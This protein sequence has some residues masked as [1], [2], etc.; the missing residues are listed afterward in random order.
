MITASSQ[1]KDVF[2]NNSSIKIGTGCTIEYNMNSLL[3]N[4][5]VT[6]DS[7][8]ETFYPKMEDGRT[9][10]YKKLFPVDTII[11][12]FRPLYSGVKYLIWTTAQTDTPKNSFFSPRRTVYPKATAIESDGIESAVTTIYPRVYYPGVTTSYKYWVTPINKNADITI[13]YSITT[14]PVVEASGTGPS[15]ARPLVT[16]KTSIPHGFMPGQTVTIT[17]LSAFNLSNVQIYQVTSATSFNVQNSASGSWVRDASGTATL[18]AATKGA[19]SNKIVAR[20]EKTHVVPSQYKFTITYTDNSSDVVGF[21]NTPSSGEAVIY[22]NG[23]AW[24]TTEPSTYVDPTKYIKSIRLEATNPGGGKA[25]GVIEVSAR[26][27]KDISSDI[28]AF[29]IA[30]ESSASS[31]DLLPVGKITANNLEMALVKYDQS[32]LQYIDYNRAS[33]SFDI[34]K[35]Y[36][37]KNAELRPYFTIFHENGAF[38]VSPNKYDKVNQGVFYIDTYNIEEFGEVS[39]NAL[40]SAKYLMETI[41]PDIVCESYP[42]T[43]IV[44]RL[45]DSVGFTNYEIR[46]IPNDT[47]I[48]TINYWWTDGTKTVWEC[49]Q[50][51]CRDIQM[52]AFFDESNILQFYTRDYLYSKTSVDWEFHQNASENK[53]PNII[54]FNKKEIP[55]A[56]Y[57]KILWQSQI[58][59]SYAGNSGELWTEDV[60][61]LSAGG[62]RS[63]IL[64]TTAPENTNLAIDIETLDQYS[65]T[66]SLY[67]YSGYV[68]IN[69][70]ILEYDAIEYQYVPHNS[71][72]PQTVWIESGADVNK[73]RFLSKPGFSDPNKPQE[74]AYFRPTGKYRVKTRGALGTKPA[75]HFQSTSNVLYNWTQSEVSWS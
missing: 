58:T 19:V 67:N 54:S 8:L 75:S 70:E 59:S 57:V 74:S 43:A 21:N 13:L 34:S 65:P 2:Y 36:L 44:R 10:I 38:G 1:L 48:P 35:I 49:L 12:P 45:L 22:W 53:L 3:D 42:V 37:V 32:Q 51:L 50:E 33:T 46:S 56:N 71:S 11:K 15:V 68:M 9:N 20:F 40:D 61:Y 14:A 6:Y 41:A 31:E 17:G 5:R 52:N 23:T 66:T 16:Y 4:L 28:V 69:S 25:I 24:V 26:W 55:G 62:L 47:S 63:D 30:K 29:D 27:I 73:Y 39:L 18:S 64:A 72:T 7:S 60:T